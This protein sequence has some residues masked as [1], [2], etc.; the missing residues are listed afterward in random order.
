MNCKRCNG[1]GIEPDQRAIGRQLRLLRL[2][3][4][5]GLREMACYMNVSHGFLSQLETG[6]RTWSQRLITL[7]HRKLVQHTAP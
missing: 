6:D 5:L 1:N 2:D 4:N 7:F 3:A